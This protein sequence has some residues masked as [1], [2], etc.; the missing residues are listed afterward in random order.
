MVPSKRN[1]LANM[2][3]GIYWKEM[4][5]LPFLKENQ[6]LGLETVGIGSSEDLGG[7]K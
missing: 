2:E 4:G 6:E 7:R 5:Q 3:K 1:F